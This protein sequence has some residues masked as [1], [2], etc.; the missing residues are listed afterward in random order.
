[1]PSLLILSKIMIFNV[2]TWLPMTLFNLWVD[3]EIYWF[4][5]ILM[6]NELKERGKKGQH[7]FENVNLSNVFW[8]CP[9]KKK[10]ISKCHLWLIVWSS[11]SYLWA[12]KKSLK[13]KKRTL[14]SFYRYK[15][16]FPLEVCIEWPLWLKDP[17]P[18]HFME[19]S[20][21][22]INTPPITLIFLSSFSP[23]FKFVFF[24]KQLPVQTFNHRHFPT[25]TAFVT[26]TPLSPH[27][28]S[29][30]YKMPNGMVCISGV[31]SSLISCKY[32]FVV[33][34]YLMA[35]HRKNLFNLGWNFTSDLWS[36]ALNLRN[37]TFN[38]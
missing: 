33:L 15:I 30:P 7:I 31:V 35:H 32:P 14:P 3:Q 17:F 38:C 13:C 18:P 11:S 23:L 21:E 29:Q 27:L 24:I 25:P 19:R 9:K 5:Y 22:F 34:Q 8:A 2:H 36:W 1:M 4:N 28:Q 10:V 37:K 26:I 12:A 6:T 16:L 20:L